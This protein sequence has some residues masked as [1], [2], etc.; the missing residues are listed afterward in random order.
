[1]NRRLQIQG[2]DLASSKDSKQLGTQRTKY[3]PEVHQSSSVGE[4][5]G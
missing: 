5:Q 3:L 1:M 2:Q 4:A